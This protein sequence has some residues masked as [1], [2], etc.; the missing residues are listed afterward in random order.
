MTDKFQA[1]S[2]KF[3]ISSKLQASMKD[4]K[5]KERGSV[6]RSRHGL[7]AR[8][9]SQSRGPIEVWSFR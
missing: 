8:C 9:G 1:P 7:R 6:T 3:Q 4:L 2:S 5:V